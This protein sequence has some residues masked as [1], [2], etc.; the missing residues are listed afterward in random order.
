MI[1]SPNNKMIVLDQIVAP[2]LMLHQILADFAEKNALYLSGIVILMVNV[3]E[4]LM[5]MEMKYYPNLK[6]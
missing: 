2:T 5:M 6:C 1:H 4:N 3:L